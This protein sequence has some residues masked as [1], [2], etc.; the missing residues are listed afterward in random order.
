MV[1][2]KQFKLFIDNILGMFFLGE[3]SLCI[4]CFIFERVGV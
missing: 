1:A 4:T 3:V 2:N